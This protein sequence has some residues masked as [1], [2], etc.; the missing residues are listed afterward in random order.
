MTRK[1]KAIL[2]LFF[3]AEIINSVKVGVL[4]SRIADLE[5]QRD[6]YASRTQNWIDRAVED[7]EVIDSLQIRLDET[8][9][10]KIEL[11]E[12]GTFFC[13][14]FR[15]AARQ[16]IRG[17]CVNFIKHFNG[18]PLHRL[19]TLGSFRGVL[20]AAVGFQCHIES[21]N[22]G[23]FLPFAFPICGDLSSVIHLDRPRFIVNR[24]QCFMVQALAA[25]QNGNDLPG[26]LISWGGD[27]VARDS[28]AG[29][30]FCS[31]RRFE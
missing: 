1:M 18:V 17:S 19:F 15:G 26:I 27:D 8:A 16:G 20:V 6:I 9:D 2:V 30:L 11:T 13:T 3:A 4:K 23:G 21:I 31:P 29:Q 10:R 28:G 25:V 14:A 24:G 7:E 12:A 22:K 5:T